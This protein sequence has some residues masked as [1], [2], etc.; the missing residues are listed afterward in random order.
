MRALSLPLLPPLG[1]VMH[2]PTDPRMFNTD[3]VAC[4]LR[5]KPFVAQNFFALGEEL[6]I[7]RRTREQTVTLGTGR[8]L[9]T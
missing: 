2:H 9:K 7:E 3:V 6:A 1:P 5:L 4:L 8:R